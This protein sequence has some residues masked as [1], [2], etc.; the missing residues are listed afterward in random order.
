MFWFQSIPYIFISAFVTPLYTLSVCVCMLFILFNYNHKFPN[1]PKNY[2]QCL[3]MVSKLVDGAD[4]VVI[5]IFGRFYAS[6]SL[7]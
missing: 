7:N 4:V 3:M 5:I 1:Y 2:R 6:A